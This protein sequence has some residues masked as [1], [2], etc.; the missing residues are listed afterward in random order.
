MKVLV[1]QLCV[2]LCNPMDCSRPGSS[3]PGILHTRT[4]EW[5][6][7][8]FCQGLP[9]PGIEAG[10]PAL[11]VDS[12]P[13]EPLGKR[14]RR[15]WRSTSCG[16]YVEDVA[17]TSWILPLPR[18]LCESSKRG[19]QYETPSKVRN[20]SSRRADKLGTGMGEG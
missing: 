2:T 3:V 19:N 10:S 13:A 11:Q 16:Q 1:T 7:I 20:R 6:A 4:L 15:R 5:V 17:S 14:T 8:P 9:H 18:L 12:L